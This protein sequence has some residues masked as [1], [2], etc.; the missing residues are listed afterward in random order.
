MYGPTAKQLE[1]MW[2]AVASVF[3]VKEYEDPDGWYEDGY[4][5]ARKGRPCDYGQ[6]SASVNQEAYVRGYDDGQRDRFED[7]NEP[8][9]LHNTFR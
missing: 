9:T 4:R 7:G 2:P 3:V 5:D 8:I 6:C 1:K